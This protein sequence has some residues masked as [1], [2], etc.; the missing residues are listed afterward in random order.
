M[1]TVT[2]N[3]AQAG[4][5]PKGLRVGLVAVTGFYSFGSSLS[6]GTTIQMVKVPAGATPVLI[7]FA[8]T[9]AGDATMSIG[10]GNNNARY[11]ADGTV[12]SG[13]AT[14]ICTIP[15]IPYTYTVD[16]TIDI[17]VSLSSATTVGGAVYLTA[18]FS[19]DI[20]GRTP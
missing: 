1:A 8:N 14:V 20:E 5:Q 17:F 11:K 15:N 3:A 7:R 4:V 19:M 2:A 9:N 18:I 13:Q 10:D 12:S 6:I 16:D